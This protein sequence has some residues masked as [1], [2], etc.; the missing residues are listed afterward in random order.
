ALRSYTEARQHLEAAQRHRAQLAQMVQHLDHAYYRLERSNT[1]LVAAR[2]AAEEAERFKAEFVVHLSHELRTPLNLIAGFSDVMLTS[3]ESYGNVVLPGPY[4]SDVLA[5]KRSARH[6]LDL[7][8][9]ILNLARIETGRIVL[10]REELALVTLIA[11]AT[12]T[13]RDYIAAKGLDL[14]LCVAPDLP[15][16]TVDRLR[17]RQVLL[18]LL[19]NAARFTVHGS[20]SI[21]AE[22]R[23]ACVLVR[24]RDTGCGIR[25]AELPSVFEVF[26]TSNATGA[27]WSHGAGLGLPISREFVEL[28]G[29]QMGVES[30]LGAGTT[31]WFTLPCAPTAPTVHT[32]GLAVRR[33]YVPL[34]ATEPVIVVAGAAQQLESLLKHALDGYHVVTSLVAD[35]SAQLAAELQ[36]VAVVSPTL[37]GVQGDVPVIVCPL[38]DNAQAAQL[39]GANDLLLKPVDRAGLLESVDR[40]QRPIER[41]LIVDDDADIARLFR[42]FLATR[43]P[44][45]HCLY[46]PTGQEALQILAS[47]PIDLVLLDLMMPDADGREVLAQIR[48][49]PALAALPVIVVSALSPAERVMQLTG[50][51]TITRRGELE[52]GDALRIV[53]AVLSALRGARAPDAHTHRAGAATPTALPAWPDSPPPQA[54]APNPA[55]AAPSR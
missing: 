52:I 15:P 23:E 36:A 7:A 46:A 50:P 21:E 55:R 24:V 53:E 28:H 43:L 6:L 9:D 14:H 29:G 38:S 49:T 45:Q 19:V 48:A 42:R 5:V 54:L 26:H 41:V 13:V 16:V 44:E 17:T 10:A 4:R 1:A 18:N 32:P 35:D 37:L 34:T 33:P 12:D 47:E 8:D 27:T 51:I 25:A 40:L 39:L 11:E 22:L 20:I 2:K 31:F 3:P 30:V